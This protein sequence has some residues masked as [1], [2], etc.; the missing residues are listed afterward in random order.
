MNNEVMEIRQL[1]INLINKVDNAKLLRFIYSFAKG[2]YD[3]N[4]KVCTHI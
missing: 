4:V 2:I 3:E 1:I